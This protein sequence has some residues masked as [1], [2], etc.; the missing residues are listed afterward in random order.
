MAFLCFMK[1]L[2]LLLGLLLT[3]CLFSSCSTTYHVK[4]SQDTLNSFV[5]LPHQELVRRLGAPISN[6]P[7][8]NGGYILIFE[9]N[10]SIFDYSERYVA[11]S[12]TLPKAEF[13]MDA[14]GFC[15]KARAANTDSVKVTS[16]GKT[17]ALVLLILLI[18]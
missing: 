12:S 18:L 6:V 5:G 8:G 3:L 11:K 13:Y 14:D 15:Y 9:G 2:L 10:R 7:D 17:I 16:V 4:Y 1:R